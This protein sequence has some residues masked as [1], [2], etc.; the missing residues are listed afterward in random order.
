M[1][2]DCDMKKIIK[3]E[4]DALDQ[5]LLDNYTIEDLDEESILEFKA[6]IHEQNISRGYNKMNDLSFLTELGVFQIDRNDNRKRKLTLGGLLFLGKE[7][8]IRSR[9]AHL[10]LDYFDKRSDNNRWSDRVST[11]DFKYPNLN[12][13]K[14]YKIVYEKLL[15]TIMIPFGL[16]DSL[17]RKSAL[18]LKDV[19]REALVNMLIHAEYFESNIS[20]K[21]TVSKFS[22]VFE[23]PGT[24]NISPKQFFEGGKSKPRNNMLTAYFRK[25]GFSE[26]AG[27]GG[28]EIS[29]I[30][31]KNNFKHPKIESLL[32]STVLTVWTRKAENLHLNLS[33][34]ERE[35][36]LIIENSDY[37]SQKSIVALTDYNNSKVRII[38]EKLL[39]KKYIEKNESNGLTKYSK[40]LVKIEE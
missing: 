25:M 38:I 37:I 6:I 5:E 7:E 16:D 18:N 10:H 31:R 29:R 36:Y 9:F 30:I 19:I 39:E 4:S 15:K 21:V 24:M 11:G 26:R 27:S 23:N 8:A 35:V 12:I 2:V 33:I 40:S 14:Y 13:L 20:I 1:F 34:E 28:S 32:G 17:V 22:Y 3:T